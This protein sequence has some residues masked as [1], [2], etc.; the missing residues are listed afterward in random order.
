MRGDISRGRLHIYIYMYVA[1]IIILGKPK[2]T[3]C[4]KGVGR[5]LAAGERIKGA[6]HAAAAAAAAAAETQQ[7]L[8]TSAA[9]VHLVRFGSMTA[10]SSK[11]LAVAFLCRRRRR[12]RRGA[13]H[14][15]IYSPD[16]VRRHS[17]SRYA[18]LDSISK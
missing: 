14:W 2:W 6:P 16:D 10:R 17:P 9:A 11:G 5:E 13:C 3:T 8:M 7:Q 1:Y 4:I 15:P 12:R 18:P